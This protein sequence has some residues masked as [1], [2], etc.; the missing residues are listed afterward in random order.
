MRSSRPGIVARPLGTA[1]VIVVDV[2]MARVNRHPDVV[3]LAKHSAAPV[4]NG[5]SDFNH[6]AR[7]W[8]TS[9]TAIENLPETKK[10]EDCKLAQPS[11]TPRRCKSHLMFIASKMGMDFIALAP[12][13]AVTETWRPSW[14][15]STWTSWPS[16]REGKVSGGTSPC[17]TTSSVSGR[18]DFVYTDVAYG[19]Y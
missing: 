17:L 10:I 11:A 1:R 3:H 18:A 7:S 8:A 16:P 4:I 14:S 13:R 9:P 12:G 5:M 2:L 19:L 15:D 6:P